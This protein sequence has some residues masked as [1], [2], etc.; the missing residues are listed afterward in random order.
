MKNRTVLETAALFYV[1][2]L[3]DSEDTI[4]CLVVF[5]LTQPKKYY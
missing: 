4:L 5:V 2:H 1:V 3:M